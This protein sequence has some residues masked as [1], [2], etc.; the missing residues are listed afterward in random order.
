MAQCRFEDVVD[1]QYSRTLVHIPSTSPSE[2]I[3]LGNLLLLFIVCSITLMCCA[4][5]RFVLFCFVF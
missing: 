5:Q 1:Y 2:E 3:F 4:C